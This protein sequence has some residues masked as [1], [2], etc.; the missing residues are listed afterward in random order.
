MIN[1]LFRNSAF[2]FKYG[3]EM[4]KSKRKKEQGREKD[5]EFI[6]IELEVFSR[7]YVCECIFS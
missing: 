4:G 3:I 1:D 2:K 5:Q 7:V 6:L